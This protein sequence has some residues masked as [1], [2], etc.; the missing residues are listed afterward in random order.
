[1]KEAIS[2][3]CIFTKPRGISTRPLPS[4]AE[5]DVLVRNAAQESKMNALGSFLFHDVVNQT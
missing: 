4:Q 5:Q 1:M 3:L 2:S